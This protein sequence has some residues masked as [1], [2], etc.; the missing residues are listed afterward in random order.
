MGKSKNEI[1]RNKRLKKSRGAGCIAMRNSEDVENN[2]TKC[3]NLNNK[4]DKSKVT[5]L[6]LED[7]QKI[8]EETKKQS[9]QKGNYV[10][11]FSKWVFNT[12]VKKNQ[13]IDSDCFIDNQPN[14]ILSHNMK[15]YETNEEVMRKTYKFLNDDWV[16]EYEDYE[17]TKKNSNT[18]SYNISA[19]MFNDKCMSGKPDAVFKNIK[20]NSRI[21]VEIKTTNVNKKRI[22]IGGWY[23]LQCQLWAYSLIDDFCDS[24]NIYLYGDIRQISTDY[25]GTRYI[26]VASSEVNYNPLWQIRKNQVLNNGLKIITLDKNCKDLFNSYGGTFHNIY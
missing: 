9:L 25:A 5:D 13:N 1:N 17:L 4:I 2:V 14:L 11:D 20:N 21:I 6:N 19:L 18:T 23:N 26:R 3:T 7:S 12:I 10:T 16:L 22:P 8:I 24:P 15:D